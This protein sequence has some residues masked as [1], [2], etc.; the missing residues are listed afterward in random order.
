MCVHAC[1]MH[2]E[3]RGQLV[4]V[5]SLLP[6]SEFQELDPGCRAFAVLF[7]RYCVTHRE[8]Q[9]PSYTYKI[10]AHLNIELHLFHLNT[11]EF[12]SDVKDAHVLSSYDIEHNVLKPIE[13]EQSDECN[14]K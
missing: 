1:G 5:G 12:G 10:P 3:I 11:E 14:H 6:P 9:W 7:V 2:V 13:E 4:K 8:P